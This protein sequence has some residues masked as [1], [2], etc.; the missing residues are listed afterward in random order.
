MLSLQTAFKRKF[1]GRSEA[2][3]AGEEDGVE[4]GDGGHGADD[5]D[6][7]GDDAG[8]VASAGLYHHGVPLA[9]DAGHLAHQCRHGLE[10][11]AEV[12]GAAIGDTALDAAGMIGYGRY[13]LF[14]RQHEV[15]VHLAAQAA[16][17]F[18]AHAVLEA[19][20]G[21]DAHHG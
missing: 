14:G 12:D 20:G 17:P 4:D 18:E 2:G 11:H 1:A 13:A 9:V 7:A 8:I 5:G 21:V 19:F 3:G 15:V 6:G 10:G 16:G